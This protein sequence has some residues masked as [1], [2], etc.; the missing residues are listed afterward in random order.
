MKIK[1]LFAILT[2]SLFLLSCSTPPYASNRSRT[3]MFGDNLFRY[4]SMG[5]AGAG[6][7]FIGDSLSGGN[8]MIGGL[9]AAAGVGLTYAL[10]KT[11]DKKQMDAY[12]KG[13]S[14]GIQ[15]GREEL[16]NEMW[17]REA[18]YGIPPE[19]AEG[20]GGRG[21]VVRN[22]YV[23]SR[24]VNNVPYSASYQQVVLR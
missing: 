20:Y 18:V 16:L 19:G 5:A 7:Y 14:V 2:G 15:Q 10:H 13:I 3:A 11:Y 23:P 1:A 4:G 22:V 8:K 24:T 17:R 21:E 12:E 6:G 9:G